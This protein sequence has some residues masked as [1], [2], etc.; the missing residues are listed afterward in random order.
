MILCHLHAQHGPRGEREL[1]FYELVKE[2]ADECTPDLTSALQALDPFAPTR[3]SERR[4]SADG[5]HLQAQT[6]L[7]G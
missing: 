3:P 7:L 2:L 5:V 4:R 6:F 1:R